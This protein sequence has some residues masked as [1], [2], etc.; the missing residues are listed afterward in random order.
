MKLQ[1]IRNASMKIEYAGKIFLTDPMFSA[2]GEIN[3]FAGIEKNPTVSLPFPTNEIMQ[4]IDG[5]LISHIHPDHFDGPASEKLSKKIP[6]FCQ[7]EDDLNIKEMGFS[8]VTAIFTSYKWQNITIHKT[9]GQHGVGKILEKM[10]TVSGFVLQAK[11][12]PTVYWVG[13]SIWYQEV[14]KVIEKYKPEIIITHSGGAKLPEMG[15]IIMDDKQTLKVINAAPNANVVAIHMESLDHCPIR[16][17]DLRQMA[18]KKGVN[19]LQLLIPQ[20]GET[21]SF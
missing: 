21:L 8:Q 9:N 17:N 4:D 19:K 2:R 5:V 13:D 7:P 11:D 15:P 20:D 14:E 12:E 1:L 3:S 18:E 16:R 10:G 6:L